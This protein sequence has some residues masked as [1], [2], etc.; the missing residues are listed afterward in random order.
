MV[1]FESLIKLS[2]FC[3]RYQAFS[4]SLEGRGNDLLVDFSRTPRLP[5]VQEDADEN[6]TE[7]GGKGKK[8][9]GKKE[10]GGKKGTFDKISSQHL[11]LGGGKNT[12]K[13]SKK[14]QILEANK[15]NLTKK[16]IESD[17]IKIQYAARVKTNVSSRK[18]LIFY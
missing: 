14:D 6:E 18:G 2:F 15:Q 11:L 10:A 7:K 5:T 13:L 17:K 9:G 12:P 16:Q 4:D 8:G 3:F 1:I